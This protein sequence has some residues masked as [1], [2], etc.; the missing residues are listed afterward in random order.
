MLYQKIVLRQWPRSRLSNPWGIFRVEVDMIG[1]GTL[2]IGKV[3]F[4]SDEVNLLKDA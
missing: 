4:T 3:S 1:S 2:S